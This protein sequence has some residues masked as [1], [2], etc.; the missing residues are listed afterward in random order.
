MI[1]IN[2]LPV[3]K[4]KA[5]RTPLPRLGLLMVTAAAATLLIVYIA[6]IFIRIRVTENNI[7][8]TNEAIKALAPK[9][10][11]HADLVAKK[12]DLTT[13]ITEIKDLTDRKMAAP[14]RKAVN[15]IW[16]VINNNP[17]VWV[18]DIRCLDERSAQSL[19]KQADPDDS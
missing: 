9:L 11:E 12:N 13:K 19:V 3:E 4:R 16:D 8:D 2:L 17:R 7:R 18:D 6:S 14:W 5:E 15:A 1:R 10:K